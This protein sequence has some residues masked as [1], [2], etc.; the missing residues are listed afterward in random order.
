[1]LPG[2][3]A[4]EK[5]GR[6]RQAQSAR[7][8]KWKSSTGLEK[9][10]TPR[11]TKS[12]SK[13]TQSRGR[14]RLRSELPPWHPPVYDGPSHT[15]IC[16]SFALS[17]YLSLVDQGFTVGCTV[18]V[19]VEIKRKKIAPQFVSDDEQTPGIEGREVL[20]SFHAHCEVAL[21]KNGAQL[22]TGTHA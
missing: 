12:S 10:Q 5:K 20:K 8:A 7:A 22:Q 17:L 3:I 15:T 16:F 1:M 21:E 4:S 14:L 11:A 6:V 18:T 13:S 9:R 19:L 2:K